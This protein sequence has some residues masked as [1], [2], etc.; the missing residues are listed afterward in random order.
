[1]ARALVSGIAGFVGTH[2]AEHLIS[3]GAE[4]SGIDLPG[5]RLASALA[6]RVELYTGD[7]G[8]KA[9]LI[10]VLRGAQPDQIYHLAGILKS[11]QADDFYRVHVLGTIA[12]LDALI[13]SGIHARILVASSSAVY[14]QG[15][16]R[17][18]I[19][20]Q[21]QL[22]PVTH[23]GVSKLAQEAVALRYHR[24]ENCDIL[25]TRTFNIVG[26]GQSP[27]MALPSFARQIAL[28]EQ[29][30]QS[31]TIVTGNLDARRDWTDVRDAVRAYAL[32][33]L[34]GKSGQVYNVCSG[35]AVRMGDLLQRMIKLARVPIKT[36]VDPAWVQAN[37]VPFQVG[38][39]NKLFRA[40]GW[41]SQIPIGRSLM[42]LLDYWRKAAADG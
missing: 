20:E 16:S 23:Y 34:S 36:H 41:R 27:A 21:F 4:V 2:L 6:N 14:G 8:D 30:R 29:G 37:D 17:R 3:Q 31:D 10:D 28:A 40:T 9:S 19:T 11:N 42:D 15:V 33:M 7:V 32:L 38:A 12:L 5:L 25:C 24:S 13:E 1:M 22:R 35:K 26:A 18:P 39:P